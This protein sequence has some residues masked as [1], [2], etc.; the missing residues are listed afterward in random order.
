MCRLVRST[1]VWLGAV[2]FEGATSPELQETIRNRRHISREF[3]P[4]QRPK[5]GGCRCW[6][7]PKMSRLCSN[8]QIYIYYM[9]G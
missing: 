8:V 4:R 9:L 6:V 2:Q 3:Q 7:Q 1:R 5:F